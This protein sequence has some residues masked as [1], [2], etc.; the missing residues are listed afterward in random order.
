[1]RVVR[2][3]DPERHVHKLCCQFFQWLIAGALSEH[4]AA[5][6]YW[7]NQTLGMEFVPQWVSLS[8]Q[9]H[10]RINGLRRYV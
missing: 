7:M 8:G 5:L 3:Q 10:E 1:M 2:V 9:G 6:G 4:I